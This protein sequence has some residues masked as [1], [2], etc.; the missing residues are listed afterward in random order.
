MWPFYTEDVLEQAPRPVPDAEAD[1]PAEL[2]RTLQRVARQVRQRIDAVMKWAVAEGYRDDK[3]AGDAVVAAL[4]G[5]E[6]RTVH[7]RALPYAEVAA[8][9]AA[10]RSSAWSPAV[11]LG[12][13]FTVLCAVRP[14]EARRARWED[15]DLDA[16]T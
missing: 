1:D 5:A 7:R 9:V 14:G 13:E 6:V 2:A 16:A 8:A 15:I 10:V 3:P 4:P 11:R 12:F